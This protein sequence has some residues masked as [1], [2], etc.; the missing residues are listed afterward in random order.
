[1]TKQLENVIDFSFSL[2]I[3]LK[4]LYNNTE[5]SFLNL[6]KNELSQVLK[7]NKVFKNKMNEY[8]N[9]KKFLQK[10][11]K[12]SNNINNIIKD[13]NDNNSDDNDTDI[14]SE[15]I[16]EIKAFSDNIIDLQEHNQY[17]KINYNNKEQYK[18]FKKGLLLEKR[19]GNRN[20]IDLN[21]ITTIN[22]F[23]EHSEETKKFK[24]KLFSINNNSTMI[25]NLNSFDNIINN[26]LSS[27]DDLGVFFVNYQGKFPS[28]TDE[29]ILFENIYTKNIDD[30]KLN[31]IEPNKITKNFFYYFTVNTDLQEKYNYIYSNK[32]KKIIKKLTDF[33]E[34]I[35]P[36]RVMIF[37]APRGTGKTSTLIHFSSINH[38]RIFYFNL[39]SFKNN[40]N[41]S[42]LKD[43]LL[44]TNKLFGIE[45][46]IKNK[47]IKYTIE[48]YIKEKYNKNI[49]GLE[50]LYQ[51][52]NYFI[53]YI[54][55]YDN[56]LMYCFV[57]D[58]YSL[59]VIKNEKDN[60]S[61]DILMNI[62]NLIYNYKTI[63]LIICPT[64]NNNFIKKQFTLLFKNKLEFDN[65]LFYY[66][67]EFISKKE[68]LKYILSDE[69]ENN[70]QLYE[71]LDNS[72]MHFYELKN[73]NS[74][75][76]YREYLQNNYKEN[77]KEYYG[78]DTIQKTIDILD[79]LDLVVGEKL[80]SSTT[81][82]ENLK[83]LPLK[84]LKIKK[85]KIKYK[86]IM[87]L[88]N[89][90]LKDLKNY[91][92]LLFNENNKKNDIYFQN[93]FE[94]E[95]KNITQFFD[96]YDELDD[97]KRNLY[98]NYYKNFITNY[99]KKDSEN[100]ID[101][102][103]DD[104]FVYKLEFNSLLFENEIYNQ[105]FNSCKSL[106]DLIK[107][108]MDK[109]F[110]GGFFEVLVNHQIKLNKELLGYKFNHIKS[111]Q[112]FV[113]N[114]FSIK[115]YST[116]RKKSKFKKLII[117]EQKKQKLPNEN[118][119][120]LQILFY[121]KYYDIALLIK[122]EKENHFNIIIFQR[123]IKKDIDKIFTK[124]EHEI[125]LTAVKK[126]VESQ[127]DIII[128]KAYFY[129][130]FCKFENNNYD[131]ESINYCINN[132][133]CYIIYNINTEKFE[134]FNENINDAII[135]TNFP[136]H[137]FIS[138]FKFKQNDNKQLQNYLYKIDYKNDFNSLD[139]TYMKYVNKMFKNK[140]LN[141]NVNINQ[142]KSY[143]I[144]SKLGQLKIEDFSLL[145]NYMTE[146]CFLIVRHNNEN[147]EKIFVLFLG[148][149]YIF[150][151]TM[152]EFK[153]FNNFIFEHNLKDCLLCYSEYPLDIYN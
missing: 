24:Y 138:L 19:Y 52:I 144:K 74:I 73:I 96:I 65:I 100:S 31:L 111:I 134:Y 140:Y 12:N 152:Q 78:T 64:L 108:I 126:N 23:L 118:I 87:N 82:L 37:S 1:M 4:S 136:S 44:Q 137:N 50:F 14:N 72:P 135:T 66:N 89:K 36:K 41:E 99:K 107:R 88:D 128:D 117:E 83:E 26:N 49:D 110:I 55:K 132:K 133:I 32:R 48:N 122:T 11:I 147:D 2:R 101:L 58:Q 129:Y 143:D 63:K 80:I 71:E 145:Y 119:L 90:V 54:Q 25:Q 120:L 113:P 105:I 109:G 21:L 39:D 40:E 46:M 127:Y 97:S 33:V 91:L 9:M 123:T 10:K 86:D 148:S 114:S 13:N 121:G 104:I 75:Q 53:T 6:H 77:I 150:D 61:Y 56:Y 22:E 34:S 8:Q 51:I 7:Q 98:G 60:E 79:L 38:L 81:L 20:E 153:S 35:S 30:N 116:K 146:F 16:K 18:L 70:I 15:K 93:S 68:I 151:D 142:F 139:N 106:Y 85:Y 59:N 95:E 67:Q 27:E 149:A 47:D 112:T 17:Y 130:V 124:L 103:I 131:I 42:K 102:N 5:T 69:N 92:L 28:L 115:H 45:S 29:D 125:I 94:I 141:E 84:F 57:I 3:N 62:I 76:A 43:L